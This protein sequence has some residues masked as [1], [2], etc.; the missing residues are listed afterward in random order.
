MPEGE[1]KKQN[2]IREQFIRCKVRKGQGLLSIMKIA[3]PQAGY[4]PAPSPC[5]SITRVEPLALPAARPFCSVASPQP[6]SLMQGARLSPLLHA[7]ALAPATRACQPH[8]AVVLLK[9]WYPD[10]ICTAL[11]HP[12][13]IP[14]GCLGALGEQSSAQPQHQ[15]QALHLPTLPVHLL[16]SLWGK[17][18]LFSLLWACGR[19]GRC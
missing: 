5:S 14:R 11:Q 1:F 16:Y 19:A 13:D 15:E 18:L 7:T 10:G 12:L 4:R 3:A 17:N 8:Q 9:L 2:E 6:V